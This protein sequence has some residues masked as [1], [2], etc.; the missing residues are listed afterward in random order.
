M[1]CGVRIS[2]CG[3]GANKRKWLISRICE[4][5]ISHRWQRLHG[6]GHRSAMTLPTDG[7][8][9]VVD[10]PDLGQG[11]L[12]VDGRFFR[13]PIL[14]HLNVPLQFLDPVAQLV[15][16]FNQIALIQNDMR[17][18]KNDQLAAGVRG[19]FAAEQQSYSGQAR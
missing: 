13:N 2:D 6:S 12:R 9:Q 14:K 3:I 4:R 19:I 18:H 11:F 16:G 15:A 10:F 17:R 5:G 1:N 8:A 7:L